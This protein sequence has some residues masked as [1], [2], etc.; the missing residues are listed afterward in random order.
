MRMN[1][2]RRN[3]GFSLAELLI[4]V[5]IVVILAAVAFIAVSRYQR[6]TK[7]MELDGIAKEIFI[8][9]QNHLSMAD[10]QGLL[11][12]RAKTGDEYTGAAYTNSDNVRCFVVPVPDSV[13]DT[14]SVLNLMLPTFSVDETV[15]LGGSYIILYDH[16]TATVL[17]V[18]YAERSSERFGH[19][20]TA[21]ELSGL[22]RNYRDTAETSRK[23]ARKNYSFGE[24]GKK[25]VIGWY[26][27]AEANGLPK[28][29]LKTPSFTVLNGDTLRVVVTNPNAAD[30]ARL[31]LIVR[32]TSSKYGSSGVRPG[33]LVEY[34][35]K[36]YDESDNAHPG[37]ATG[38][39]SPFV[40][41]DITSANDRFHKLCPDIPPG[42]DVEISIAAVPAG[43]AIGQAVVVGPTR[44]NS[45]FASVS[46]GKAEISSFRH[47]ENLDSTVSGYTTAPV[48]GAVQSSDLVWEDFFTSKNGQ[49]SGNTI[50][51]ADGGSLS[52]KYDEADPGEGKPANHYYYP[53]YLE[54]LS[55]FTY[56]GQNH[57]VSGV[58][59]DYPNDVGL[60][61]KLSGGSVKNLEL[62]D[63]TVHSSNSTHS[64]G[65][66][67]GE[68]GG[69]EVTNV[70]AR[71][72]SASASVSGSGS[73]GGL[74]GSASSTAFDRCAASLLVSSSGGNAGG[75][76]GTASNST[77]LTGCY[78]GGRTDKAEYYDHNDSGARTSPIYNVTG[79]ANV[80]GLVGDAGNAKIEKSYSTCSVSG[81]TVGGLVGTASGQ[82][83]NCYATGLVSGNN[84]QGAFAGTFTGTA[85]GC[86]Y[87]MIINELPDTA[88]GGFT[89][90]S[91]AGGGEAISGVTALDG[92]AGTYN[93]FVGARSEWTAA[94][95]TDSVLNVYYTGKFP[96]QNVARLGATL[97][98][99]NHGNPT[100]FVA[101]HYGDWPAP[102][103][104]AVNP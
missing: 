54:S 30:A 52:L 70:L 28:V 94:D 93:T 8:A 27:G 77:S 14:T 44:V 62:L 29:D 59:I 49:P 60:F 20:F 35:F 74:V 32:A 34:A 37:T 53:L 22:M 66:L 15:R 3:K 25:Y 45:L 36:L 104:R 86:H 85:S 82:I 75:L 57:S 102:E 79:T 23:D 58:L 72:S 69:T 50:L 91:A 80:G 12:Q 4:V 71:S 95:A 65:T 43:D 10:S 84:R 87:Y 89:Y 38:E 100:D 64:A 16:A 21:G 81:A 11:A 96:L 78:S 9:A 103:L 2:T 33:E 51:K 56:D 1:R 67:A 19:D 42:E 47:L 99:D 90:L 88:T 7:R 63:F 40:L 31:T 76:L 5:A 48:T 68:L 13:G 61:G 17:D 92:T 18:F 97:A 41:D 26:G 73:V 46:D 24:N 83:N 101:V 6:S 98:T 39:L 55:G